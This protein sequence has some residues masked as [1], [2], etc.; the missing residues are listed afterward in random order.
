[1]KTLTKTLAVIMAALILA[2]SCA[3]VIAEDDE[4]EEPMRPPIVWSITG[5]HNGNSFTLSADGSSSSLIKASADYGSYPDLFNLTLKFKPKFEYKN[6]AGNPVDY[7]MGWDNLDHT[8]YNV[9]TIAKSYD[10][11]GAAIHFPHGSGTLADI[12]PVQTYFASCGYRLKAGSS[13][14]NTLTIVYP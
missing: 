3:V 14:V 2:L 6:I 7:D 5:T 11:P 13:T 10:V 4:R 12:L 9:R 8:R 1:M